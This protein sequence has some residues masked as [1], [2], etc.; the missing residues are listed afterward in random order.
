MTLSPKKIK[1]KKRD[2]QVVEA[3]QECDHCYKGNCQDDC[4]CECHLIGKG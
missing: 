1:R 4:K 2:S 3:R